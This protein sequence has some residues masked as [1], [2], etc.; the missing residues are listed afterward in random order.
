VQV[1]LSEEILVDAIANVVEVIVEDA[2][3][4]PSADG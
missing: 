4:T 1:G 2:Q 3:R